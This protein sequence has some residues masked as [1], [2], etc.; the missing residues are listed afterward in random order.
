MKRKKKMMMNLKT[1]ISVDNWG[2]VL[3][4]VFL[5][6]ARILRKIPET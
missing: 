6:L 5:R 1:W 3:I 4:T 2:H